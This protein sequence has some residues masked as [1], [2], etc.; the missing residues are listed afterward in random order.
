MNILLI[1][2]GFDIAHGLPTRYQDFLDFVKAF[3]LYVDQM[4]YD[5]KY[6]KYFTSVIEDSLQEELLALV[7]DN[8]WIKFFIEK[9]DQLLENGKDGWIDFEKEISI[10][11]RSL[12]ESECFL[13][14]QLKNGKDIG[15]LLFTQWRIIGPVIYDNFHPDDYKAKSFGVDYISI[16]KN[17]LLNDLDRLI[18]GLEIYLAGYVRYVFDSDVRVEFPHCDFLKLRISALICFNYTSTYHKLYKQEDRPVMYSYVHGD[19]HLSH[20]SGSRTNIVLGIDE[21]LEGDSINLDNRYY[22]FKKFYQRIY[23]NTD[24]NYQDIIDQLK[25]SKMG[26]VKGYSPNHNL[27][28]F[29]HSLDITDKDI[30]SDLILAPNVTT[31]IYYHDLDAKQRQIG[32]LIKVIGEIELI[33]RTKGRNRSIIFVPNTA[34]VSF[35]EDGSFDWAKY[36][37]L[38]SIISN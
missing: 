10:V 32:N 6:E 24:T 35:D 38:E 36:T 25:S 33:K 29:G 22:E 31:I 15:K 5:S 2:N 12:D 7:K 8:K 1:G 23:K 11:I 13:E 14:D 30:L 34:E 4:D 18:R 27:Y 9:V 37:G 20:N 19:A 21:Y 26:K 3:K 28:I 17:R 16:S